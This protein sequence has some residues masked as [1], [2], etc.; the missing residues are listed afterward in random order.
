[1]NLYIDPGTGSMLFTILIAVIGSLIYLL[2]SLKVRMGSLI[3]RG[4]EKA[5]A[6]DTLP[7]VIFSDHKRYWNVFSPIC[8]ELERR[9]QEAVYL[10]ESPD[11]PALREPFRHIHCE[12][13]GE[14]NRAYARLNFLKARILLS[15]TPGLDV[16]Q[17]KRSRDVSFYVHIPHA[18]SD[19]TLYRMFGL[20]YYDAVLLSGEYQ[21]EQLRKL[22]KLRGLPAKEL[23]ITGIPFM[24]EMK[25]RLDSLP[26][27]SAPGSGKTI[28]LAP[29]W[30][31]SSLLNVYGEALLEALLNTGYNVILRPH[32]QSHTS[33]KELLDRLMKRFPES[34]HLEWNRD[35]DNF[36]A[37]RRA[38][39]LISDFSGV[40]F[41]FTLVFDK[42]V[43]YSAATF[44]KGPYDCYWLEDSLWTF[45]VLPK[46]G[47]ELTKENLP[48]LKTL[49]DRC[50]EDPCFQEGRNEARAETWQ[51]PGEG[52][53]RTVDYLMEKLAET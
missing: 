20:D 3:R 11:D 47:V 50:L 37:L 34:D 51:H 49:I 38:D 17:W 18:A 40:L 52:A 48:Q 29:S 6:K 12:W 26:P 7:L 35:N 39:L 14:G 36:E 5:E 13:I 16:Y 8:E 21:Q 32:P 53:R 45:D 41:D 44:D 46:L 25:K 22:E 19:I 43:I 23:C 30:G 24:D 31:P 27:V 4:K 33:E 42:P 28:L 9:G 10:T 1:M 2:R 15:T